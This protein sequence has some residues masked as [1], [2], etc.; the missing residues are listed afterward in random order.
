MGRNPAQ[1]KLTLKWNCLQQHL[2]GVLSTEIPVLNATL[3]TD[4]YIIV[5]KV[6]MVVEIV[7]A[8]ATDVGD[9]ITTDGKSKSTI[10][11]H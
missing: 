6:K 5:G 8:L 10:Q 4:K 1:D 2:G 11:I 9:E 3:L 7:S